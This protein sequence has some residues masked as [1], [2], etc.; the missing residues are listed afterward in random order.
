MKKST[1]AVVLIGIMALLAAVTVMA[2]GIHKDTVFGSFTGGSDV[3]TNGN[4]RVGISA[5]Y[6]ESSLASNKQIRVCNR[7]GYTNDITASTATV[8]LEYESGE[9]AVCLEHGGKL[10]FSNGDTNTTKFTIY[11]KD[12]TGK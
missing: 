4:E 10:I 8:E 9:A 11:L 7:T 1:L 6:L 5:V 12:D 3:Y 2:T